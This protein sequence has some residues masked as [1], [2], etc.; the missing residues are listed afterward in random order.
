MLTLLR[1]TVRS[2]VPLKVGK[3]TA[4]LCQSIVR[5]KGQL[6]GSSGRGKKAK[7]SFE[8]DSDERLN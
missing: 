4:E 7:A 2:N 3:R 8:D 5:G 6:G 1:I